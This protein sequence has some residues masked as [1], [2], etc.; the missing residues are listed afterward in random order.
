MT[1]AAVLTGLLFLAAGAFSILSLLWGDL[2][3]SDEA[4]RTP[5]ASRAG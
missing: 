5:E 2:L 3:E 1:V 4:V